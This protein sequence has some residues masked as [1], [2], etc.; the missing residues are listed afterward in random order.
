[1]KNDINLLGILFCI[2]LS[3]SFSAQTFTL[4]QFTTLNKLGMAD[5][6]KEMKSLKNNRY[7]ILVFK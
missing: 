5:F 1:M 7:A 4:E 3:V 2:I 6:K